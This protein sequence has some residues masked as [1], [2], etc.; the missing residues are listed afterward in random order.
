MDEI[1]LRDARHESILKNTIQ[2]FYMAYVSESN[3][4]EINNSI[5]VRCFVLHISLVAKL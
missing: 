3:D 5:V 4:Q 2:L 1:C